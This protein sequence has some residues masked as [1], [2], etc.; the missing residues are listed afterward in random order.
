VAVVA[1]TFVHQANGATLG[2]EDIALMKANW[3]SCDITTTPVLSCHDCKTRL[4]CKA[5]G[6]LMVSCFNPYRPYCVNGVCSP[7]PSAEC[8]ED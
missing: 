8:A 2:L 3:T 6:G 4:V 5:I 1:V 7:L